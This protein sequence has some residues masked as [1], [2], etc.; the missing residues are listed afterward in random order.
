M[1]PFSKEHLGWLLA[2]HQLSPEHGQLARH[3]ST[4]VEF[5]ESF[6]I[7]GFRDCLRTIAGYAN[8]DGGYLVYGVKDSIR[9][10]VGLGSRHLK[11]FDTLDPARINQFLATHLSAEIDWQKTL[12]TLKGK[13][14][15]LIFIYPSP[16]KPVICT[17]SAGNKVREGDIWY[18]YPGETKRIQSSELQSL[19]EERIMR[20][21]FAWQKLLRDMAVLS[22][23]EISVV[24]LRQ[25]LIREKDGM[26]IV[27]SE[28]LM[29]EL[30][31]IKQGEFSEITGAP[32]LNLVGELR[33]LDG[34]EF[35]VA[36]PGKEVRIGITEIYG[37]WFSSRCQAPLE[38]IK[39]MA[40]ENTYYLPIW[41]FVGTAAMS[42]NAVTQVLRGLPDSNNNVVN[43]LCRRLNED[44]IESFRIADVYDE[45][46]YSPAWRVE[47]WEEIKEAF[48]RSHDLRGWRKANRTIAREF[49]DNAPSRLWPVEHNIHDYLAEIV[50]GMTHV[51]AESISSDHETFRNILR[52]INTHRVQHGV[53]S[54]EFRKALCYVDYVLHSS[55]NVEDLEICETDPDSL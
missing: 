55:P 23:E 14:V 54:T 4:Q 3:E 15:G 52:E 49:L 41:F 27:I 19:I 6:S 24:D 44:C 7:P 28:D 22:P 25:G 2:P 35:T 31:F 9:E 53:F 16:T 50:Q 42:V 29:T 20:E 43:Q 30:R 39:Q 40:Y 10:V 11:S 13:H 38:Y 18:R 32:T 51:S 8:N 5:K 34:D 37:A 48:L 46:I 17:A 1:D 47:D 26:N 21:R 36:I 12:H 45:L 33:R